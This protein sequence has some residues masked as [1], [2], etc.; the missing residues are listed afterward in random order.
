MADNRP[1]S[2]ADQSLA[3][4]LDAALAQL[5]E[6]HR[7]AILLREWRGL[8]YAEIAAQMGLTEPAVETM[9][10]RARRELAAALEQGAQPKQQRRVSWRDLGWLADLARRITSRGAAEN[11]SPA[12]P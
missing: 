6:R 5:S 11:P 7:T 4:H 8:S 12:R 2:D 1:L 3:L 9:L 10:V